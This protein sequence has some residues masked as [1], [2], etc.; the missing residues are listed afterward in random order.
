MWFI[1]VNHLTVNLGLELQMSV[2]LG[3]HRWEFYEQRK[4]WMEKHKTD[5]KLNY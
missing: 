1:Q 3:S 5:E 4:L 2:T